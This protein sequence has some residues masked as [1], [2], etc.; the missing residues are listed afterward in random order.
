MKYEPST[1]KWEFLTTNLPIEVATHAKKNANGY[2]YNDIKIFLNGENYKS[3]TD[4][5][6]PLCRVNTFNAIVFDKET[7]V[8]L[9]PVSFSEPSDW[10][11]PLICGKQPQRIYNLTNADIM[12]ANR[13]LDRIIAEMKEGDA[14]LL[15]SMDSLR[16][17]QW[18][19]EIKTSLA[20][21]GISTST[22]NALV[23]GQPSIFLGKKGLGEGEAIAIVDNG[24]GFPKGRQALT[25]SGNVSGVYSSAQIKSATIGPAKSWNQMKFNV[26]D[27]GL[28]EI[29]LIVSGINPANQSE[30]LIS[31]SD[32]EEL[33]LSQ[34]NA[35]QFPYINLRFDLK[36][37]DDQKPVELRNWSVDYTLPA[38]GIL[39]GEEEP[40]VT[41][42][43]GADYM[44]SFRFYNYSA[45]DFLDSLAVNYTFGSTS[46]G[47]LSSQTFN[48]APLK[49]GDTAT[50]SATFS[51]VGKIGENNLNVSVRANEPEQYQV[52][53]TVNLARVAEVIQD[54]TNPVLDVTFDGSY[55][56]NGDIVSPNPRI[57]VKFKDDNPYLFK[58]DTAGMEILLKSPCE[59]CDFERVALGSGKVAYQLASETE[60]FQVDYNPGPLTD[61]LY[62]LKVQGRDESG[63][64]SGTEP[65]TVSFE[66]VNES[67]ITRFYPYPNPFSTSTRFVF[68]LTGSEIPDQIKI[69]I[70]TVS[71]RVVREITDIGPIKIGNNISQ[72]AWDGRDEYG[73]QLAN[74]VYLYKVFVRKGGQEI[75]NRGTSADRA[76]KHGFGKMYILR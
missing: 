49:A 65:Y 16:Y 5:V 3:T 14:I 11:N 23:D 56:L 69:Q 28:D 73:D 63:N 47:G 72:Y 70:M 18:D 4:S 59:G 58:K 35:E 46:N 33:D 22:V 67:T 36:D 30:I 76:F 31:T 21:V 9:R 42:D 6:F 20:N 19:A 1:E 66:V 2:E 52:N 44:K 48:I 51:T 7:T 68:T 10:K 26:G 57:I 60:D 29:S 61:G 25:F 50:F 64:L 8:P 12:G 34:I 55:I 15:F 45:V 54:E 17:S 41:L 74:G 37:N 43:E 40:L 24:T 62:Q 27:Q 32:V 53:N 38:E 39:L 13:Y 71:G 75:K